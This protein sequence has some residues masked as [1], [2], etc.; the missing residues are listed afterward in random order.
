MVASKQARKQRKASYTAM[1]HKRH[2]RFSA[3]LSKELKKETGKRNLPVRSGD[4]VRIM[5]GK[6]S[7]HEGRIKQVMLKRYRITVEG[8]VQK[9]SKG[10]DKFYPIDPSNV[11][12]IELQRGDKKREKK[13]G[14]KKVK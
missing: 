3:H 10:E 12:V 5:R 11:V 13:I 2:A 6:F 8:A 7:G 14:K 9:N 4:K 1:L